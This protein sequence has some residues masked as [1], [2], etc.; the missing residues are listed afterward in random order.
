MTPDDGMRMVHDFE[1]EEMMT[2]QELGQ[3]PLRFLNRELSWLAFNQRVLDE[4]Y[5]PRHPLLER[6]RFLSIS[7]SN[8]DEFFAVRY[9]GVRAQVQAGVRTETP[10]GMT[11]PMQL[12]AI[13]ARVRELMED[14]TKCWT[15]IKGHLSEEG[16]DFLAANDLTDEEVIWLAGHYM[17]AF[18][19]VLTPLAIDPAHPFPFIPSTG[20]AV[21]MEL[22][23]DHEGQ[24]RLNALVPLPPQLPRLIRL[25][26][27][28]ERYIPLEE[29]VA[30]FADQLFPGFRAGD[31]GA[32]R[33]LRDSDMEIDEEAE[34]LVV[35][36]ET[37]LK[38]RKR[39]NII[40]LEVET[41]LSEPQLH[42]LMDQMDVEAEDL[43]RYS[44]PVGLEAVKE[45]ISPERSDLLFAP[46]NP[47][48]PER[49]REH[50]NEIFAAIR[51]KDFLV[52]H[53]Y[54]SF[55][56]VIQF[57]RQAAQ[58]PNVL[59]IKQTL[60]RTSKDS[61]IV[62]AL[63]EA[64]E[65]GKSVT[66]LIE[67][68]A[69][70]DE[71]ANLRWARDME[72][73]GVHVVLGVTDFKTH[74]KLSYVVRRET[75]GLRAYAHVGTGNY[76]PQNA[77]IYTDFSFFS[78]DPVRTAEV[79][80]VFNYITGYAPPPYK[81]GLM[82]APKHLKTRMLEQIENEVLNA[83]QGKPAA[84]WMKCNALVDPD[85]IDALY[86]ASQAGVQIELVVRG[87]CCLRP[88]IKGLSENIRVK[89]IIGRFLEHA[90]AYVFGNGAMIPSDENR[91][92]IGSSDMMPR[93]LDNRI[94]VLIPVEDGTP[95]MQV[96]EQVM[97]ANLLD[98]MQSFAM[99]EDG[100]YRRIKPADEPFSAQDYFLS[101][102]SL[103][104]RGST[105]DPEHLPPRLTLKRRPE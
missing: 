63:I 25:P 104:G 83:K 39:G 7:A 58:D 84:I 98:D 15:V 12:D 20:I 103:S 43:G 93:N 14:Q 22:I 21:V 89:S 48:Y 2:G 100:E 74:A 23:P 81:M 71:E 70:F 64:A 72:R 5:N 95:R 59:A 86:M 73:A 96:L 35:T 68:K 97:V 54:E 18:L 90:R 65:A 41:S 56:V 31:N 6:L 80:R 38:R 61:P 19:P 66:A 105:I 45:L 27:Q 32:F 99:D 85:I 52:H 53:P 36:F 3:S 49:L 87:I 55:E 47:R 40:W 50:N 24:E 82:V 26:G 33:V 94:E 57:L 34:D 46:H 67:L 42:F 8:L 37:A 28:G 78:C 60:Y 1:H 69:R 92:F 16:I 76:H 30:L 10:D 88:G 9:A 91:V 51:A 29:V 44:H 101:N 77:R 62:A 11:P 102:P 4:A 75:S 17:E 13:R 79:G